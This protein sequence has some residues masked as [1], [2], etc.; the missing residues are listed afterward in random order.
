MRKKIVAVSMVLAMMLATACGKED[1][2]ETTTGGV[3]SEEAQIVGQFCGVDLTYDPAEYL[4]LPDYSQIEVT[5]YEP[6]DEE[7][8]EQLQKKVSSWTHNEEVEKDTVEEGDICLIDYVGSI[9]GVEFE[10]G[11]GTDY[12]LGIGSNAFIPGF[13]SSLIGAKNKETTTINVTFPEEYSNNPDMA[14]KEAQ[15]VVTIK[16]IYE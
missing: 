12:M 4:T 13:E 6:T 5:E 15:C 7:V 11:A 2:K 3:V 8:Q 14:G 10:G 16:G 1:N 9:D